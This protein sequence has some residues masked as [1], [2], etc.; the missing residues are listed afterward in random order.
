[1]N[2]EQVVSVLN[3]KEV[4]V[5][6]FSSRESKTIKKNLNLV[7]QKTDGQRPSGGLITCRRQPSVVRSVLMYG[8]EI[9]IKSN[10]ILKPITLSSNSKYFISI[11]FQQKK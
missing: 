11:I 9:V 10:H 4:I 5:K 7:H 2:L 6:V 1:M 3:A 8:I